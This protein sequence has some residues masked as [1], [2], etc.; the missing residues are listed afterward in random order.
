MSKMVLAS[1]WQEGLWVLATL[2]TVLI[3]ARG[4]SLSGVVAVCGLQTDD[5][6]THPFSLTPYDF[7]P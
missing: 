6:W 1:P 2:L 3:Y 7:H 5:V 4:A